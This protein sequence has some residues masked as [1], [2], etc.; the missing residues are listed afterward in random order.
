MAN[1]DY[2]LL[3][4]SASGDH[5]PASQQCHG[6]H[7]R[8]HQEAEEI[9]SGCRLLCCWFLGG[10]SFGLIFECLSVMVY[11]HTVQG[12]EKPNKAMTMMITTVEGYLLSVLG[13]VLGFVGTYLSRLVLFIYV[14][15]LA[16]QVVCR[17]VLRT[18]IW[19]SMM[20]W[21]TGFVV[22]DYVVLLTMILMHKNIPELNRGPVVLD[23]L[24]LGKRQPLTFPTKLLVLVID[25]IEKYAL[26]HIAHKTQAFKFPIHNKAKEESGGDSH[27]VV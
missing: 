1:A 26:F 17:Q 10:L 11:N 22:G 25:W 24:L 8:R 3:A 14:G 19:H 7:P 2:H 15:L 20:C 18:D 6:V 5:A 21:S 27:H 16:K 9:K 12:L 4:V 13:I 23:F